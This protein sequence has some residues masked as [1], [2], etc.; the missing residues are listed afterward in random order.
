MVMVD[1]VPIVFPNAVATNG[2]GHVIGGILIPPPTMD[3]TPTM[4]PMGMM[5][6]GETTTPTMAPSPHPATSEASSRSMVC[7]LSLLLAVLL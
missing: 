7:F 2:I 3:D 5:E 1:G 6:P 4:A